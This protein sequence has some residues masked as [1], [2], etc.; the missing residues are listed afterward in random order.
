MNSNFTS[1]RG[2][3]LVS[4]PS[5]QGDYFSRT[6]ILLIEHGQAGAFGLV[7]NKPLTLNLN[8][9]FRQNN[10]ECEASLTL[11]DFGPVDQNRL[12]FLHSREVDFEH[13]V[14][15]NS[16]VS[17]ATSIDVLGGIS[18]GVG[19]SS[20]LAGLGYAGWS[21]GQLDQEIRTDVWLVTPYRH[22]IIF[23]TPYSERP[24]AAARTIGV[25]LNL[26]SPTSGHG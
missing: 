16:E 10:I 26:I 9:L 20:I 23:G 12:F 22:Q 21:A 5:M 4:M 7:V 18:Q 19:P 14:P 1:L 11:F 6:V 25:D 15:V 17:L 2:Q 13:S 3:L 24:E 8:E